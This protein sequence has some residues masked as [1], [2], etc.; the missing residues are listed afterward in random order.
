[1]WWMNCLQPS[2][3]FFEPESPV[4]IVPVEG[5]KTNIR[6][7]EF[8]M[9]SVNKNGK[10]PAPK[11]NKKPIPYLAGTAALAVVILAVVLLTRPGASTTQP[12][13]A[14]I[15]PTAQT[16][17]SAVNTNATATQTN[18]PAVQSGDLVIQIKDITETAT[19]YP[20]TVDGVKMEAFA[21]KAPDGTIRTALNTCQ[22]CY[23]S[24]R[25]YY[26]QEGDV[27][28][29]QNCG[30]RFRTS[31]VEKVKGGCNPVPVLEDDKVVTDS[32]ITI[33][34]GFLQK[35]KVLFANWKR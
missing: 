7:D 29:C 20:V 6:K 30:N 33:P 22:V 25:G 14:A 18:V 2:A 1:M 3:S 26:K 21:V 13:N 31:D 24:G 28:V 34:A 17:A 15:K 4:I 32:T 8:T 23:D 12:D 27:L 10:K 19:F 11:P 16:S 5:H 9:P 35:A